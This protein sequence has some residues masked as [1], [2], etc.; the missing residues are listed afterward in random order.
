MIEANVNF[1]DKNA[2]KEIY[3]GEKDRV[4][5]I[6]GKLRSSREECFS[7]IAQCCER[8]KSTFASVEAKFREDYVDSDMAGVMKWID[9]EVEA[10]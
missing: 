1:E 2:K 8:S 4:Q 6:V 7:T 10:F 3:S 5:G 9:G